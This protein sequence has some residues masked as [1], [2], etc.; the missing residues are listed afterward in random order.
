M[1]NKKRVSAE[2]QQNQVTSVV[3]S[4]LQSIAT[5]VCVC[6]CVCVCCVC[7]CGCVCCVCVC[8]CVCCVCVCGC[9]CGYMKRVNKLVDA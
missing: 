6:V 3:S 8:G 9:V 2:T 5:C 4:S 7:V 1:F